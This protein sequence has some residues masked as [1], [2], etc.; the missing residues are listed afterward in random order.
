MPGV[1]VTLPS[2]TWP[3]TSDS[4]PSILAVRGGDHLDQLAGPVLSQPPARQLGP[5]LGRGHLVQLVQRGKD[6]RAKLGG[7]AEHLE[8]PGQHQPGVQLDAEPGNAQAG[9]RFVLSAHHLGVG[10]QRR[11]PERVQVAL[12]EFAVAALAWPVGPPHRAERVALVRRRE[13]AAVGRG[14]PGQRH[15]QVVA[16]GQVR[17]AGRLVLAA[18]QDL[19]DELVTFVAVLAH[20]HVEALEGRR[21]QRLEA[22]RGVDTVNNGERALPGFQLGGEEIARPRGRVKLQGH[23]PM[24]PPSGGCLGGA[25]R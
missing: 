9:Q 8:Q 21:L 17:L 25:A 7:H 23:A 20:E 15:G 12:G 4:S 2:G 1:N 5:D 16:Q 14:D 6:A 11:R 22:V 3:L 24:V 13:P 10:Q 19:E 18:P